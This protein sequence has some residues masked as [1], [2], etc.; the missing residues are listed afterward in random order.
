MIQKEINE[1]R[2]RL[3]PDKG[4]ISKIYGCFVNKQKEVISYVDASVA[5]MQQPD[6]E[7]YFSLFKKILSGGVGRSM[8]D[9]EFST[10]Q[11][12]NGDE[13]KLLMKLK[14]S[15]LKDEA[16]REELFQKIISCVS[17][18]DGNYLILLTCDN[19]DVPVKSKDGEGYN[20]SDTVFSY[21]LCCVCPVNDGKEELGY[22]AGEH[23]FRSYIP[24]M[25]VSAP[26]LGFM[27]PA[28]QDR[29]ANIYNALFYTKNPSLM[30]EE[31]INTVFCTEAPM[32]APE[33][34]EIFSDTLA[35]TLEN[36]C[37]FD[38]V[39]AVHEKIRERI[40]VHKES[41]IPE[42]IDFDAHDVSAILT[43]GGVSPEAAEAFE[44]KCTE[45][46]GDDTCLNPENIINSKKF[47]I[48]TPQ[49]KITVDPDYS[50]TVETRV[51]NGRKYILI[52]A[53]DGVSVNG[54]NVKIP[55]E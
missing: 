52:P 3:S 45:R 32:S 30:H 24:P 35:D 33:Q 7:K 22:M 23:T 49:I 38:V 15:E 37:S 46:F 28:F 53:D 40:T 20:D 16:A 26:M 1:I 51:I 17:V 9:I 42:P 13:H 39:Q 27:F 43:S 34:K 48:E 25:I 4:A 11:V 44:E 14:N 2:R 41:K 36:E 55:Q 5:L 54:I 8:I 19:Y 50:C 18:E 12:M 47:E 6:C 10:D 31:F 29:C 21:F